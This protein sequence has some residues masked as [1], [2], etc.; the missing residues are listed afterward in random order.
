MD[1]LLLHPLTR[2]QMSAFL[3]KPSHGLLISGPFGAG[4]G[5]V[6]QSIAST[7]VGVPRGKLNSYAYHRHLEAHNGSIGIGE[8]RELESFF[9][10]K[11]P[12]QALWNRVLIIENSNLLT[13]EA[14]NALLK[15]LEE[16][17]EGTL[18]I[19]TSSLP[20]TLLPTIRSRL[21]HVQLI[22]PQKQ[23]VE[24]YFANSYDSPKVNQAI[25]LSNGLPGL[26]TALLEDEDHELKVAVNS[27]KQLLSGSQFERLTYSDQLLKQRKL[28][29]QTLYILQ[30]MA[31]ISLQ[32]AEG[33]TAKKWQAVLTSAY[34]ATVA[35][36]SNAQP[37]LV[38]ANLSLNL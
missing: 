25:A 8:V 11:V 14:Q 36:E 3:S 10:L 15:T 28:L 30:Q 20:Q 23:D 19:M 4:K 1:D 7:V 12:V 5:T 32:A 2:D 26:M 34:D 16:P 22:T 35:L 9:G 37:K 38:M 27:A 31:H 29:E 18:I 24:D 13:L 33:K 21:Q 6:A 17:P